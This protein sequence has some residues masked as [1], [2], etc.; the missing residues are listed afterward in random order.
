MLEARVGIE[1]TCKGFA[2]LVL[3]V[4]SSLLTILAFSFPRL[5]AKSGPSGRRELIVVQPWRMR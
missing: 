5:W 1:P 2:D 3:T 4:L